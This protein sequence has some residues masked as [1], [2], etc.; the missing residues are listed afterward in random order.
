MF[1]FSCAERICL[2]MAVRAYYPQV[3]Q[4]VICVYAVDVV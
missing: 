4:T 1:E 2:G 3:F